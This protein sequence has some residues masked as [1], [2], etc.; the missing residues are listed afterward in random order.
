MNILRIVKY[1]ALLLLINLNYI[2]TTFGTK[3]NNQKMKSLLNQNSTHQNIFI[4]LQH[5]D[6]I[7]HFFIEKCIAYLFPAIFILLFT[8]NLK[9]LLTVKLTSENSHS[10]YDNNNFPGNN[11]SIISAMPRD[12]DDTEIIT[13][14]KRKKA[15]EYTNNEINLFVNPVLNKET[16]IQLSDNEDKFIQKESTAITIKE[17]EIKVVNEIKKLSPDSKNIFEADIK[18]GE[19]G[20]NK[21][22]G[23]DSPG[24]NIFNIDLDQLINP[25]KQYFLEYEV[26]GLDASCGIFKS[27]N[28]NDSYGGNI[29]KKKLL[30]NKC[31]EHL[32]I[33]QLISGVNS[34]KFSSYVEQNLLY[35]IK[36]V[37]I[38][39]EDITEQ[40]EI[41]LTT[42]DIKFIKDN[43]VYVHGFVNK[44]IDH[45]YINTSRIGVKNGEFEAIYE[46]TE[47]EKN[48]T[49]LSVSTN[50]SGKLINDFIKLPLLFEEADG[51]IPLNN[52]NNV[53]KKEYIIDE[54]L[55]I[56]HNKA[57]VSLKKDAFMKNL[58]ISVSTMRDIDIPPMNMGLVNVTKNKKAYR[59]LPHKVKFTEEMEIQIPYDTLLI[60]SGFQA[61]DIKSFYF[62]YE[63]K[64]WQNAK[65]KQIDQINK[66]VIILTEHFG[67]F[68][69]GIIQSPESPSASAF[70][71]TTMS[72][73][74]S[75]NPFAGMNIMSAPSPNQKGDATISYPIDIPAG[76]MGMQPKVSIN[77]SSEGGSGW[78]GYG[79]VLPL[80]AVTIDSRWGTPTFD[81]IRESELYMLN[82]EQLVYPNKYLPHR[83]DEETEAT[84]PGLYHVLDAPLRT[85]NISGDEK[86]FHERRL[87]SLSRI[88]RVGTSTSNYYWKVINTNGQTLWYG[89]VDN[90]TNDAFHLKNS[91]G[92]IFHWALSR[93]S[94]PHGN[95]VDYEY[96]KSEN[97]LFI[98]KI[99]YTGTNGNNHGYEVEFNSGSNPSI[100][101]G[102]ERLDKNLNARY[103]VLQHDDRLLENIK[104]KLLLGNDGN[105]KIRRYSFI[106]RSGEFAKTLLHKIQEYDSNDAL[107]YEHVLDYYDD[108]DDCNIFSEAV[109]VNLPC[110]ES[111]C[112]EIDSDGDG[113][114]DLCDKCIHVFDQTNSGNCI[115][116]DCG[117]LDSDGD[118][119]PDGC[120]NCREIANTGNA[121]FDKDGTGDICD[122]CPGLY[123]ASQADSDKDLLGDECDKCKNH[124]SLPNQYNL[125]NADSD[126]DG[127]G[128]ACDNCDIL[129]NPLQSDVDYDGLGDVCDNCPLVQNLSQDNFDGDTRGDLCD[130]C[131]AIANSDQADEDH[132]GIGDLC[133]PCLGNNLNHC[134]K[135]YTVNF[136]GQANYAVSY[137]PCGNLDKITNVGID[138]IFG[139]VCAIQGSFHVDYSN[140]APAISE[141]SSCSF[142]EN[143]TEDD[144][145]S[146]VTF[147]QWAYQYEL[148]VN[149]QNY[150]IGNFSKNNI[151]DFMV[152]LSNI[153]LSNFNSHVYYIDAGESTLY[154]KIN[155]SAENYFSISSNDIHFEFQNC[156]YQ[157]FCKGTCTS[158]SDE[159]YNY[160]YLK[161]DG[162]EIFIGSFNVYNNIGG[163]VSS[164]EQILINLGFVDAVVVSNSGEIHFNVFGMYQGHPNE[165]NSIFA[166]RID[167]N[168]IVYTYPFEDCGVC[169]GS[170]PS[171][172]IISD[173]TAHG[174]LNSIKPPKVKNQEIEIPNEKPKTNLQK[175]ETFLNNKPNFTTERNLNR[176][177]E[178]PC[179]SITEYSTFYKILTAGFSNLRSPLSTFNGISGSFGSGAGFGWGS[180]GNVLFKAAVATFDFG[181][182]GNV[183]V[184]NG[185]LIS[186]DMNGDGLP[187]ILE[188]VKNLISSKLQYYPH[189]ISRDGGNINHYYG[190]PIVIQNADHFHHT[191]SFNIGLNLAL[192]LG[193]ASKGV[194]VGIGHSFGMSENKLYIADGNGDQLPDISYEGQILFNTLVNSVENNVV[195]NT[196]VF[197]PSSETSE[198]L[199][200]KDSE[201]VRVNG[202]RPEVVE[203]LVFPAVDV[204]KV[205]EANAD[206]KIVIEN[207]NKITA[208][209][210]V[211]IETDNNGIYGHYVSGYNS[212]TYINS[213]CRLYATENSNGSMPD[214]LSNLPQTNTYGLDCIRVSGVSV[215][216]ENEG[217]TSC[218]TGNGNDDG[219]GC[220]KCPINIDIIN[221]V[222]PGEVSIKE[223]AE[224]ITAQNS[225]LGYGYADYH[226]NQGVL[227]QHSNNQ[228]FGVYKNLSNFYAYAAPC[229][230]NE[231][232]DFNDENSD[233]NNG[234]FVKKGQRIYFR[235]HTKSD[236]PNPEIY[237]D[238]IVKYVSVS[239]L[240]INANGTDQNGVEPWR[241]SYSDGFILTNKSG[242]L[243]PPVKENN[244]QHTVIVKSPGIKMTKAS[245]DILLEIYKINYSQTT[246]GE[247]PGIPEL[248]WSQQ[249]DHGTPYDINPQDII[250]QNLGISPGYS[251]LFFKAHSTSNV[252]WKSL[253]WDPVIEVTN[254]EPNLPDGGVSFIYPIIDYS[255]YKPINNKITSI[256]DQA[257]KWQGF[258]TLN[259]QL[260]PAH[261]IY[262]IHPN[263][264]N[265]D[266][267]PEDHESFDEGYIYMVVKQNGK[268]V[269]RRRFTVNEDGVDQL[270]N[271]NPIAVT[272]TDES[273]KFITIDFYS[274]DNMYPKNVLKLFD[275]PHHYSQPLGFISHLP[276]SPLSNS[277]SK[278]IT[279]R[280]VNLFEKSNDPVG[281]FYRGWGQFLYVP[282]KDVK[283]EPSPRKIALSDNF[284]KLINL[285]KTPQSL[286]LSESQIEL[287]TDEDF[288]KNL[289]PDEIESNLDI[290]KNQIPVD[291]MVYMFPLPLKQEINGENNLEIFEK[292][293][294]FHSECFVSAKTGRAIKLDDAIISKLGEPKPTM[295][296]TSSNYGM[297]STVSKQTFNTNVTWS[298]GL[299]IS[300]TN[301]LGGTL[302]HAGDLY[303]ESFNTSDFFDLNG[304]RYPDIV[305]NDFLQ[306]T[307]RTGGL[308]DP[309]VPESV[310][311]IKDGPYDI[312]ESSLGRFKTK[313]ETNSASG[314]AVLLDAGGKSSN[315]TSSKDPNFSVGFSRLSAGVSGMHSNSTSRSTILWADINGDGLSDKIL[316]K[317]DDDYN[318][319]ILINKGKGIFEPQQLPWNILLDY[320]TNY[321]FK[322]TYGAGLGFSIGLGF[323]MA[324]G[325][326]GSKTEDSPIFKM[327]D[328]NSDGL[329]DL[330]YNQAPGSQ[331]FKIAYN[332][333][334]GFTSSQN[335][336]NNPNFNLNKMA[337]SYEQSLNNTLTVTIPAS[338]LIGCLRIPIYFNFAP[339]ILSQNIIKKSIED[340]DGDGFP[341]LLLFSEENGGTL[342]VM[343]NKTARTNKIK[344]VSTPIGG[345]YTVDY[346][347]APS[348]FNM[349]KGKYVVS[350][351]NIYDS[352]CDETLEGI[353]ET[354][355]HFEFHNGK[356]DR[357]EREFNGFEIMRVI[358]R[359]EPLIN[360][361]PIYRQSVTV[362]NNTSYY[363]KGSPIEAYVIAGNIPSTFDPLTGKI[364]FDFE[365]AA[366]YSKV[367]NHY[368]LYKPSLQFA[369]QWTIGVEAPDGLMY[370]VGATK[371]VG[372]AFSKLIQTE[373]SVYEGGSESISSTQSMIYNSIGNLVSISHSGG[374][375]YTTDIEYF[376]NG[377]FITNFNMISI[378]KIVTVESGSINFRKREIGAVTSK[379]QIVSVREYYEDANLKYNETIIE[380]FANGNLKKVTMPAVN[381]PVSKI[382]TYDNL[383][384][385]FIERIVET[386]NTQTF[387]SFTTYNFK[388]GNIRNTIDIGGSTISFLYDAKG[389]PTRIIGPNN[390][391]YTIRYEYPTNLADIGKFAITNHIDEDEDNAG[392]DI[393]LVSIGNGFG[394]VIQQIKDA[395]INESG[396]TA[397][398]SGITKKD[399]FGRPVIEFYPKESSS[400]NT[401]KV[402]A[403]EVMSRVISYDV[404][405]R[406]VEHQDAAHNPT[407]FEYYIDNGNSTA[408]VK[409]TIHQGDGVLIT[410]EKAI[411]IDRR[412]KSSWENTKQTT[413]AYDGIGQLINVTDEE[414]RKTMSMFDF[415]GRRI[416]WSHPDAG[417]HIYKYDKLGRLIEHYTPN[418]TTDPNPYDPQGN[419]ILYEYDNFH[420]PKKVIYPAYTD[421]VSNLNNVQ[422]EYYPASGN[423]NTHNNGQ[424]KHLFDGSGAQLFEYGKLGE[425][426]KNTRRIK[427]L[428]NDRTFTTLFDY[429]S[430]NRIQSIT[431][432]DNERVNYDYDLGGNL[433]SIWSVDNGNI[434]ELIRY[435][436]YG[437]KALEQYGN[438]VRQ[439]FT[440]N[441]D[442][443]RLTSFNCV[444]RDGGKFDKEVTYDAISNIKTITG[445]TSW[446]NGALDFSHSYIYDEFNRLS[447]ASGLSNA[448]DNNY[449]L[450]MSYEGMHRISSKNQQHNENGTE[451][452]ANTYNNNY[453]YNTPDKPNAVSEIINNLTGH[454]Q[455]FRYDLNGN[456]TYQ[457]ESEHNH[458]KYFSWDE[459]NMMKAIRLSDEEMQ[460]HIYDAGG[461]RVIK[462][463]ARLE[464]VSM[465]GEG[466]SYLKGTNQGVPGGRAVWEGYT[467]YVN[468]FTVVDE[469]DQVTKHYY[470]GSDRVM[471]MLAGH[472]SNF[473][474][475]STVLD[476]KDRF[477]NQISDLNQV[478]SELGTHFADFRFE[479]TKPP[480]ENCNIYDPG[481]EAY[482]QCLC[483]QFNDCQNLKYYFHNDHLGSTTILS[484]ANGL[485]YQFLLYLPWGEIMAERNVASYSTPYKFTGKERD[486]ATGFNYHGA[487][488]Y[489]P[490]L[491]IWHGVDPLSEYYPG[492]S[493]Y[494]Y[495]FNS[496]IMFIDPTGMSGED[497]CDP[498]FDDIWLPE[499][500]ITSKSEPSPKPTTTELYGNG[501]LLRTTGQTMYYAENTMD[502]GLRIW[503]GGGDAAWTEVYNQR[504]SDQGRQQAMYRLVDN[505]NMTFS[506]IISSFLGGGLR[507]GV[508]GPFVFKTLDLNKLK[509]SALIPT[510]VGR[511]YTVSTQIVASIMNSA[512]TKGI[513]EPVEIFVSGGKNYIIN[514]H[515]RVEAAR[516]LG[517]NVPVK[518]LDNMGS[519]SNI[520]ELQIAAQ[521][522]SEAAFK[523]DGRLLSKLLK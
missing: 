359:T 14:P 288:W 332:T 256:H 285:N 393:T 228:S 426:V 267:D 167:T 273:S 115:P 509:P 183:S 96:E 179:K 224:L 301:V 226:A 56:E 364:N 147:N 311:N 135:N 419:P 21:E 337:E 163:Y 271:T 38:V 190:D 215:P 300:F 266:I 55:F 60:P 104:V 455:D 310:N 304:D 46:L 158:I 507:A 402:E 27:I 312:D 109:T 176:S 466:G 324:F 255:V 399:K 168:E 143:S 295:T 484:D 296:F 421:G 89:G 408:N 444:Y 22:S 338:V 108:I 358:D 248:I 68:I 490:T 20:L 277:S 309:D 488:Y 237:W 252:D 198:N 407:L 153:V 516:R 345:V 186:I 291:E 6:I 372:C 57:S 504:A 437:L 225:I 159:T 302:G 129:F 493:P 62:D 79:W 181:I 189:I 327:V 382:Y 83:H 442:L 439:T 357:R 151:G 13:L 368:K 322:K 209:A 454:Q 221:S 67:D 486:E 247:L 185:N 511:T 9:D 35:K 464:D 329:V 416:R 110:R 199:V 150:I 348:S 75:A 205:W 85:E 196:P 376:E 172:N 330:Y 234:I 70:A 218:N 125:D 119:I 284:G 173:G 101:N 305:L 278:K 343:H 286:Q 28:S 282:E 391:D 378:P 42:N 375:S 379:G 279:R 140:F 492:Y 450:V 328:I 427:F 523:V 222:L 398:A 366:K 392:E 317:E 436:K 515:H 102:Y 103:G 10:L 63:S 258:N 474:H 325:I 363:I 316:N 87:G 66:K 233:P 287:I 519:Y 82:G 99:K 7:W 506:F 1:S 232:P 268:F 413:F 434:I 289:S 306:V 280:N 78:L 169:V 86:I 152:S 264:Q 142:N 505:M 91:D 106:Y 193:F 411:D 69:N 307:N 41:L 131:P 458:R 395:E 177:P 47:H 451:Q 483:Q 127:F 367:K 18:E 15:I 275:L 180:C 350:H 259:V 269:G 17:E 3:I 132:D 155:N 238:P 270:D 71:P 230:D 418:L 297:C 469:H 204:V 500:I 51:I 33:D 80:S 401:T 346:K 276:N 518:Y 508:R 491:S 321:H 315:S 241:S 303:C 370:D 154:L 19:I 139:P 441:D 84:N 400:G 5:S 405:D 299:G 148:N 462:A 105:N 344:S 216:C 495:V 48:S 510:E 12:K 446:Q 388:Y 440:Y 351:V 254:H 58:Q 478:A 65:V 149:N 175:F 477:G 231:D 308:Y 430:W 39:K 435:N 342:S 335:S 2:T 261:N 123:N 384:S 365:S 122:N 339:I 136:G 138:S 412:L 355:K 171:A 202:T 499:I 227:M 134:C 156:S 447:S 409:T 283:D 494:L 246:E 390:P 479:N 371:G 116:G 428:N 467:T 201:L 352:R 449:N 501:T 81:Q 95:T 262:Y 244:S 513:V 293:A 336:C 318:S 29:F 11:S 243:L 265:I 54:D 251:R 235:I 517:I 45:I 396:S 64:K 397:I 210:K 274:D 465:N 431:Y 112:G 522:A 497:P 44:S 369:N 489:D 50:M 59:F 385:Q 88:K 94:D 471:S 520:Y 240:N 253:K 340:F 438:G 178:L 36:N 130:N 389:R 487:R 387:T 187:D 422:F 453:F 200:I 424:L 207:L 236:D 354:R 459:S 514:G 133:D 8:Y 25:N 272:I 214:V 90:T 245:D 470:T 220:K 52:L 420:R 31:K 217:C 460:Y 191:T 362:Y 124:F 219:L 157:I 23:Y 146:F 406:P 475:N 334:K 461:Q 333:G 73:M 349:P 184:N 121:D 498:C 331:S 37:K 166:K 170:K 294:G 213:T 281:A 160:Y 448:L 512:K 403:T 126:N 257:R 61:K 242:T 313:F 353:C 263:L 34:I 229:F 26:Y 98:K 361:S 472:V 192:N 206:G 223:A 326:S 194:N 16:R 425:V 128:T 443:K 111:E 480:E 188:R 485:P 4:E 482:L 415:A 30:W 161:S 197:L 360:D 53:T 117:T 432:P 211:S 414:G 323:D 141:N 417:V 386:D 92:H 212:P 74:E 174:Y 476:M 463:N 404:I 260:S 144:V 319:R 118:S 521:K 137:I 100:A 320:I 203:E 503:L 356:F 114:Y 394:Q 380:Y 76:R 496:P 43:K 40:N 410:S 468:G 182:N 373:T 433:N 456:T 249:I 120:D 298:A 481:S 195:K 383:L 457:R 49:L 32:N 208:G 502:Q 473:N 381:N 374:N 72:G 314:S 250:I 145:C 423:T 77:Y 341:D 452:L 165:I 97:N 113:I 24:D 162:S 290:L 429:D 239:G 93:I 445:S 292:Y 377:D 107:F 164:A 347:I